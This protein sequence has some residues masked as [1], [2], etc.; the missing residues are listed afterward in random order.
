MSHI[1]DISNPFNILTINKYFS[2]GLNFP[3]SF[4]NEC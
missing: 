4:E 3:I 1:Y 2:F